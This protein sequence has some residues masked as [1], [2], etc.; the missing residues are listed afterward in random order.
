MNI[1]SISIGEWFT[2]ARDGAAPPVTIPLEGSSMQPLIRRSKDLVTIVPLQRPL[3][4][5]DVVLFTTSPGRYVVHRVWKLENDRVQT[6]GD[7]CLYPDP[8][9]PYACILGQAVAFSRNGRKYRLD[10]PAS[11]IWGR[12]WMLLYPIRK[13]YKKLRFFAGR[14]YRRFFK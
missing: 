2:L 10:T 7:N 13:E 5:G 14:C 3:K 6:L 11:R 8:W 9:L 12:F 4:T 1:R